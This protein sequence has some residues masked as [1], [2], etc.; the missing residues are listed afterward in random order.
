M[1]AYTIS[2]CCNKSFSISLDICPDTD[3]NMKQTVEKIIE[4]MGNPRNYGENNICIFYLY[5]SGE[6]EFCSFAQALLGPN[7]V[8]YCCFRLNIEC[9]EEENSLFF[10]RCLLILL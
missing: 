1:R 7:A 9:F 4:I 5:L 3:E 8:L 10:P 2:Q 6:P